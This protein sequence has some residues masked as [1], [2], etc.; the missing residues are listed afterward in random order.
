MG[1]WAGVGGTKDGG[2][3]DER[4]EDPKDHVKVAPP[5]TKGQTTNARRPRRA[6]QD[7]S[8]IGLQALVSGETGEDPRQPGPACA[9]SRDG[10]DLGFEIG[11]VEVE[12]AFGVERGPRAK[13]ILVRVQ[14]TSRH[15]GSQRYGTDCV[16]SPSLR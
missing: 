16:L 13:L 7:W 5:P 6:C 1:G 3:E 4:G 10:R 8:A 2:E 14:Q 12:G 15:D 9:Q 11:I